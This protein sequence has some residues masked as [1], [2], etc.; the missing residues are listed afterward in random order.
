MSS[1]AISNAEISVNIQ[2]YPF[3]ISISRG[4]TRLIERLSSEYDVELNGFRR[5]FHPEIV[6][7][8]KNIVKVNDESIGIS[9]EL[10]LLNGFVEISWRS[11]RVIDKIVDT[12]VSCDLR[13]W[14]GQGEL[15]FQV[16]PLSRHF[17]SGTPYSLDGNEFL[18]RR[19]QAPLWLNR[20]GYGILIDNYE[21]FEISF[22]GRGV[23]IKALNVKDFTYHITI[24]KDLRD[25]RRRVLKKIGLPQ[26]MPDRRILA[27]PIFSTWAYF[28]KD[29][30]QEKVLEFAK[31]IKEHEFPCSVIEIDDKW[32]TA[33]GDHEFDFDRFPNPKDMI[34]KIHKM[35]YLV[36]LWVHPF[37]NYDSKN[38]EYAKSKGYLVLD[39]EEDIP[40]EVKWWNGKGGLLDISNPKAREWFNNA[41][42]SLKR[43]YD[44]DGFKFDAGDAT[45]LVI[46]RKGKVRIGRTYGNLKPNQYTDEWIRFIAENHYDLAEVRVGFLAQRYGVVT[47]EGDKESIWGLNGGLYATITQALTLSI[48]GY[49][50]I[51]P[52]M[53]GGN[54]YEFKCDKELFIRWVEATILMPIVQ[55]SIPPWRYDDETVNISKKYTLLH[56]NLVDY[57]IMLA[58]KAMKEGDPI[59]TPLVLRD[60][61]DDEGAYISDEYL[62]GN[63]L[64]APIVERGREEREV[65]LPKGVWIDIWS[66]REIKGPNKITVEAPLDKLPLYVEVHDK[67]LLNILRRTLAEVKR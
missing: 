48:T 37:I 64:V 57:Y 20:R 61:E 26:R 35:G 32:E 21:L 27:K 3:S 34:G 31:E 29:I 58:K 39:P 19:I 59:V 66:D 62:V 53:I 67:M 51:M 5:S 60:P 17:I 42:I 12:W 1:I 49:P 45:Y 47:R 52:D 22:F 46:R 54:E 36:T 33:Y 2:L 9:L 25:C 41:L 11:N 40:M 28:K 18:A 44:V 6:K 16:F 13:E 65:Y 24:G 30:N 63:L 38:Y 23:T 50:Y 15:R 56:E 14:Y 10:R 8:E 4:K 43:R 7:R 55:Y